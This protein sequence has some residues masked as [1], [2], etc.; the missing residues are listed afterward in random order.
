MDKLDYLLWIV[1]LVVQGFLSV[2]ILY[3]HRDGGGSA[4]AV[5]M[6]DSNLAQL[7]SNV[8]GT[9]QQARAVAN[10]R[11]ALRGMQDRIERLT[12]LYRQAA[13]I[14]LLTLLFQA[15]VILR[16]HLRM[17]GAGSARQAPP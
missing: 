14:G 7:E 5:S 15:T 4:A 11:A 1:A 6:L 8:V 2:S 10:A 16:L 9:A 13:I 3:M 12:Y 17:R